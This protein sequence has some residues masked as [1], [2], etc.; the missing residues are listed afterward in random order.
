MLAFV[1]APALALAIVLAA[2][3]SKPAAGQSQRYPPEARD[4]DEDAEQHSDL[5][6][7]VLQPHGDR[8]REL[9]DHARMLI[10]R[11][12]TANVGEARA[13]L[14]SA[15]ELAPDMPDAYWLMGLL[16]EQGQDWRAC[17]EAYGK[18]FAVAPE[19]RP[20]LVPDER[21]PA[22]ALDYGLALC[23]A[24]S[25]AYEP[26]IAHHTRI[27]SRG[28]T[29]AAAVYRQ[30]GQVY[31]ALGRLEEAIA[32]LDLALRHRPTE[33]YA[34]Y[35]LAVAH[36]RNG[37]PDLARRY[38]DETR[39]LD[40]GRSH[41]NRPG[42]HIVPAADVYYHMG[43]VHA[44][45]G[46]VAWALVYFRHY[47]HVAG[48]GPWARRARHHAAALSGQA[49]WPGGLAVDSGGEVTT[50]AISAV[51]ARE[52]AALQACV[53]PVPEALFDLRI[54]VTGKAGPGR[55]REP[56]PGGD[57]RVQAG[58]ARAVNALVLYSFAPDVR[59]VAEAQRCLERVGMRMDLPRP[60]KAPYMSVHFPMTARAPAP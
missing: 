31:M 44:H 52:A 23:H 41:L 33:V 50:E 2:T 20:L 8:Y 27:L 59:P 16:H 28:F 48:A 56:A 19:F 15:I 57:A 17:A 40:L 26:A 4:A 12:R 21:K 22:W 54:A 32:V 35:A 6:Q 25:G 30:L 7:R 47:L 10:N 1:L 43:L 14:E 11:G 39:A 49:V 58:S 24:Q 18:A 38:L 55:A 36:D 37:Q 13:M 53:A 45:D 29:K 42:Q 51:I 5:W 46:A 34:R 9:V 60:R 3:S